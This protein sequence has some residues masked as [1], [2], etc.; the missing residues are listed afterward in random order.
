MF[1]ADE[2]VIRAVAPLRRTDA[3]NAVPPPPAPGATA[4]AS[5]APADTAAVGSTAAAAAAGVASG[6]PPAAPLDLR[7]GWAQFK[8]NAAAPPAAAPPAAAPASSALASSDPAGDSAATTVAVGEAAT[9]GD[10][11]AAARG[12]A[13]GQWA[14]APLSSR[15]QLVYSRPNAPAL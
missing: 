11:A 9:S 14:A 13:W 12:A 15:W 10:S 8:R 5:P 6:L 3:P 7:G 2:L 4:A 1:G